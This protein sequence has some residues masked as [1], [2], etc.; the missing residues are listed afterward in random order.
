MPYISYVQPKPPQT[1]S[2]S[3]NQGYGARAII[4]TALDLSAT[5]LTIEV[6]DNSKFVTPESKGSVTYASGEIVIHLT[7]A[8]VDSLRNAFYRIWVT[9]GGQSSVLVQGDITYILRTPQQDILLDLDGNVRTEFVLPL[10]AALEETFLR[11]DEF[12]AGVVDPVVLNQAVDNKLSAH[13]SSPSPHTA[14]D[15]DM[16][17]L[18]ILFENRL[19]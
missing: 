3:T 12:V 16:Q 8:E 18:A 7:A 11:R 6:D 14:Y 13:I 9:R 17:N 5:E 19:I 1:Y 10:T 4:P 15:V 2:F